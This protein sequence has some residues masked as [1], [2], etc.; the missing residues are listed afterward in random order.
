MRGGKAGYRVVFGESDWL[1]GLVVDRYGDTLV[2]QIS[3]AGIQRLR[4]DIVAV[5]TELYSPKTIFERSDSPS[6]GEEGLSGRVE[7]VSGE[8]VDRVA[9]RE[10]GVT[11][12][13]DIAEGQKTGFFLDQRRLREWVARFASGRRVADLFSYSGGVGCLRSLSPGRQE[14]SSSIRRRVRSTA[15]GDTWRPMAS[16]LIRQS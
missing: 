13:A 12:E 6:R 2:M 3:T 1:P 5:L 15:C 11:C 8:S 4:D 9:F 10:A 16:R 14:R 7:V